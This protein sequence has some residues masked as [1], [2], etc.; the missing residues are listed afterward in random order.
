MSKG[1][2]ILC[3]DLGNPA[4]QRAWRKLPADVLKQAQAQIGSLFSIDTSKPPAKLH[5]HT[6]TSKMVPSALDPDKKVK[7]FTIHLTL[8]DCYKASFTLEDGTAYFRACG[9]HDA[10]DKS[11]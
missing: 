4:F 5:L 9:P 8:N 1:T 3:V 7:V 11:P 10:V 2:V 6:L